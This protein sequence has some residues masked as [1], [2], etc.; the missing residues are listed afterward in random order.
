[1][2]RFLIPVAM[3]AAL[4]ACSAEDPGRL[5]MADEPADVTV[6]ASARAPSVESFP[7]AVVSERS[8]EVATRMSGTVEQVLVDVGSRVQAGDL[9]VRLD[10]SDIRARMSAARANMELAERSYRRVES[11]AADGA[12][13]QAELDEVTARLEAAR[14]GLEEAAVQET[15]AEVRA[16]FAGEITRRSVDG[17]DLAVPGRPLLTMVAPETLKVTADLPAHRAGSV[18]PGRTVS[19]RIAGL[20]RPLTAEV[21]RVV[22][23]L[24]AGSRTFRVEARLLDAPPSVLSG[25]YARLEVRRQVEGPRWVPADAVVRRGQL[26]GVYAVEEDTL[27]LRWVR[28]GEEVDGAVELLAA[29]GGSLRVVRRPAPDLHDGRPVG[30][31]TEEPFQAPEAAGEST[32]DAMAAATGSEVVR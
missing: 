21:A 16:P 22:N 31:V 18:V 19:V 13:S 30:E 20:D 8:A 26:R 3:T 15:Y 4:A 32:G 23:A 6:S 1:M 24:G 2:K 28:L 7:A 25:S 12:A 17:G 11:L 14:A 9:L 5:P 29:P 27:R 10:A